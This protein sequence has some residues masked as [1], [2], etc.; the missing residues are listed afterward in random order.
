LRRTTPTTNRR[1]PVSIVSTKSY[2]PSAIGATLRTSTTAPNRTN[3]VY[4]LIEAH[5]TAGAAHLA[6]LQE[7][8]RLEGVG[9]PAADSIVEQPCH[10]DVDAFDDLIEAAALTLPG[11]QAW[12]AYLHEIRETEPWMFDDRGPRVVA[13]LAKA[14][15][16]LPCA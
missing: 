5:R 15:G 7:Q 3:G 4:S 12:A 16:N 11:L 14:I 6:A 10:A 2:G 9:D 1:L 13:A 8:Y